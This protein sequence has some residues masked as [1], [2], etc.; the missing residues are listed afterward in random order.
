MW[1]GDLFRKDRRLAQV[2]I[3]TWDLRSADDAVASLG[4]SIPTSLDADR[5]LAVV[6]RERLQIHRI[7]S[8]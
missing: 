2:R 4:G 1:F 5:E 7:L 8:T 3:Q 6:M